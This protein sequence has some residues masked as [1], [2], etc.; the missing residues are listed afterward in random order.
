M[1]PSL[2]VIKQSLNLKIKT[3]RCPE[4]GCVIRKETDIKTEIRE[5][6]CSSCLGKM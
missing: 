5:T 1:Q 2:T 4:C 3:Y 6:P